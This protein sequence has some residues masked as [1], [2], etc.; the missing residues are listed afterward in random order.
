MFGMAMNAFGVSFVPP[1][2]LSPPHADKSELA[3]TN[4]ASHDPFLMSE[5]LKRCD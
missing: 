4:K 3:D 5:L 2:P 1:L